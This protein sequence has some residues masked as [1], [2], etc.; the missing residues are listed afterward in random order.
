[1]TYPPLTEETFLPT[2][3]VLVMVAPNGARLSKSDHPRVPITINE[4]VETTRECA[5]AGAGALHL[6]VRDSAQ[7]HSLN[8]EIYRQAI[9][10]LEVVLPAF[11]VQ[12][13]TEAAGRY[14]V[15]AQAELLAGLRP[16][17]FS[18]SISEITRVGPAVTHAVFAHV[19]R[20]GLCPQFIVYSVEDISCLIGEIAAGTIPVLTGMSLLLVVGRHDPSL[21]AG[22]EDFLIMQ[23]RIDED[24]VLKG[25]L[26]MTCA[27]GHHETE[28]LCEAMSLGSHVRVGFENGMRDQHGRIVASNAE[29]V[30]EIV[31]SARKLGRVPLAPRQAWKLLTGQVLAP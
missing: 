2:D 6:H 17:L 21:G 8:L 20:E 19:A 4:I 9:A 3:P 7:C 24:P 23:Q 30:A 5:A 27:F 25:L 28:I 13:T 14:D 22:I 18:V 1:M 15:F 31:A 26:Q 29:R 10:A 11:P 12:V 16:R